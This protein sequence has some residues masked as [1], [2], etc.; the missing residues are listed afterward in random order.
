MKQQTVNKLVVWMMEQ[1]KEEGGKVDT[2]VSPLARI[3]ST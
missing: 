2:C 1:E 3:S